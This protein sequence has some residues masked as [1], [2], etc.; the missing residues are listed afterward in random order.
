MRQRRSSLAQQVEELLTAQAGLAEHRV[1][2][3]GRDVPARLMAQADLKDLTR[4]K[5]LFPRF[6]L[7]GSDQAKASA[8]KDHPEFP[9]GGRWHLAFEKRSDSC[10]G[11]VGVNRL[12]VRG[13]GRAVWAS[14][15]AVELGHV[16]FGVVQRHLDQVVQRRFRG[17]SFGRE[18]ELGANGNVHAF[19]GLN[20]GEL[21]SR[22]LQDNRHPMSP[23]SGLIIARAERTGK[24]TLET[25]NLTIR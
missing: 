2:Q 14:A 21:P 9:V 11:R 8:L 6:V 18:V 23:L 15:E 25:E 20:G 3:G 5:R 17:V 12:N 22:R 19:A 7:L 24:E 1:E 13:V 16:L 4:G 10:V